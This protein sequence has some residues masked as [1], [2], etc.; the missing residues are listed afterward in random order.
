[1]HGRRRMV[2]C[3]KVQ[4]ERRESVRFVADNVLPCVRRRQGTRAKIKVNKKCA[5]TIFTHIL[6]LKRR[7]EGPLGFHFAFVF[8]IHKQGQRSRCWR[9]IN[10]TNYYSHFKIYI[11]ISRYYNFANI[12]YFVYRYLKMSYRNTALKTCNAGVRVAT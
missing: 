11:Y 12:Y 3:K 1:M 6:T 9:D 4:L 10:C 8:V 7:V 5:Y 2:K